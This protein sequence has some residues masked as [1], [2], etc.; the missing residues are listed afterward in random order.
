M[1]RIFWDT[2][3]SP[4]LSQTTR[5]CNHQR[6]KKRELA[7]LWTLLSWLTTEKIERKRKKD[8]YEDLAWELKK[9]WNMKVTIIPIVFSIHQNIGTGTGGLG[10][11]MTRGDHP[12]YSII[13]I[14]QNT[15]ESPEDLSRLAVT[16]TNSSEKRNHRPSLVWKTQKEEQ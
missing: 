7:E 12:N 10:K 8:K 14:G 11:A 16:N 9:L 13:K 15:Q 1:I 2:N 3:G 6:K 5:F 4:N